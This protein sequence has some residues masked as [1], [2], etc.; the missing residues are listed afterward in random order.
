MWFAI[1]RLRRGQPSIT[2]AQRFRIYV[3][4]A[5][6]MK[7][8][9]INIFCSSHALFINGAAINQTP[10]LEVE[11]SFS[12]SPPGLAAALESPNQEITQ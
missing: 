9:L 8:I 7:V 5:A 1:E 11:R 2:E 12:L 3:S 10:L 4:L 6:V